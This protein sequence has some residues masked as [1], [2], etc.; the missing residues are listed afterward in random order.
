M[1]IWLHQSRFVR[2]Q[3]LNY[4]VPLCKALGGQQGRAVLTSQVPGAGCRWNFAGGVHRGGSICTVHGR[5]VGETEVSEAEGAEVFWNSFNNITWIKRLYAPLKEPWKL[6]NIHMCWQVK[7]IL[8]QYL[9]NLGFQVLRMACPDH[10]C[11]L[12]ILFI[13]PPEHK[14]GQRKTLLWFTT[15]FW[16]TKK[17]VLMH[18]EFWA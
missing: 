16:V 7:Q 8:K 10:A 5:L 3:L 2:P 4:A 14:A 6:L 1:Q 18:W 11:P 13:W 12:W 9:L 17:Y 15:T